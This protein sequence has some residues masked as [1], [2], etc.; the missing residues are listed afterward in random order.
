[1]KK[2]IKAELANL[3]HKILQLEASATYSELAHQARE[4]HERLAVLSYIEEYEKSNEPA[5]TVKQMETSIASHL[6]NTQSSLDSKQTSVN[7]TTTHNEAYSVDYIDS[8][9][10]YH[11]PDGTQFSHEEPVHEPV[12]EKIK[13]M[14]PEMNPVENKMEITDQQSPKTT[15]TVGK[16]DSFE[17]GNEYRDIPTFEPKKVKENI[18]TDAKP[19]SLNDRLKKGSLNI[20]L[21]D[22][23][24]FIKHLFNGN[25]SDYNRVLSQ[26]ETFQTS[27]EALN[28]IQQMI[29][30]DYGNWEGKEVQEDRFMQLIDSRYA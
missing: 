18:A 6:S 30:P 26:L 14:W 1:M 13:D 16:N 22:K 11:R 25:T 17:I 15:P 20:G 29:K 12:I 7:N 8:N 24:A 4:V 5:I 28:F 9:H 23:L 3:A 2:Y 27:S 19:K 21:N 10:D